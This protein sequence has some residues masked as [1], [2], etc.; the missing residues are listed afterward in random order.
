MR[1]ASALELLLADARACLAIVRRRV[2]R[3]QRREIFSTY[4][5]LRLKRLFRMT[6]RRGAIERVTRFDVQS[7]RFFTVD[8]LFG[9]IFLGLEYHFTASRPD[10]LI[11]DCGS[12]IGMSVLYFK[13][14]YPDAEII[15]FEPSRSTFALLESN[16]RRNGL[17]KVEL[18]E[19]ALA[20]RDGAIDFF[21]DATDGESLLQ[22]ALRTRMPKSRRTVEAVR[23]SRFID[24]PVDF[25]KLDVEGSEMEVLR[26]LRDSGRLGLIRQM[27]V[28]YHHHILPDQDNLSEFLALLQAAGFSYQII[29]GFSAPFERDRYQDVLVYA[30]QRT[31]DVATLPAD[32]VAS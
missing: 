21:I 11:I 23:L 29:A 16:V 19:N 30:Y 9:E 25:L 32:R 14:L 6:H 20:A 4:L 18:H 5:R 3:G 8:F 1:L 15:A 13:F 22:S 26:E 12:N 2:Y 7:E 31:L 10:P 28:E 27:V 17:T 24:R